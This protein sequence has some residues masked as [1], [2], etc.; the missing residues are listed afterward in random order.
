MRTVGGFEWLLAPTGRKGM[1]A[2]SFASKTFGICFIAL[3][4]ANEE[5]EACRAS[6]ETVLVAVTTYIDQRIMDEGEKMGISSDM[7]NSPHVRLP[8]QKK[9]RLDADVKTA[10]LRHALADRDLHSTAAKLRA[11]GWISTETRSMGSK[12][13]AEFVTIYNLSARRFFEMHGLDGVSTIVTDASRDG[14]PKE[15]YEQY[16]FWHAT[17]NRGCW[18]IPKVLRSVGG[19]VP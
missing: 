8:G 14:Q 2:R 15:N 1:L 11:H 12:M 10:S 9:A 3:F 5:C 16:S 18:L 17:S 13:E 7:L 19:H 4:S 6:M